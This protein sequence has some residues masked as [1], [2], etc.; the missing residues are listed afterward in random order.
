MFYHHVLAWKACYTSFTA[1]LCKPTSR[2]IIEVSINSPSG[3]GGGP[4]ENLFPL[5]AH[6]VSINS[7][8]GEGGGKRSSSIANS[9][10]NVSINSPSGEGG[11]C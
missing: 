9:L 1:V 11:G 4:V 2:T 7:P 10:S 6:K 3:E 8:S 5:N